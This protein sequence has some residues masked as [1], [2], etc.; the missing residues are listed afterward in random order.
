[1]SDESTTAPQDDT[2]AVPEPV[3]PAEPPYEPSPESVDD[4]AAPL[5]SYWTHHFE[6]G[7]LDGRGMQLLDEDAPAEVQDGPDGPLYVLDGHTYRLKA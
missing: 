1:M 6:G 3:L 4:A 2:E 5:T 7:P